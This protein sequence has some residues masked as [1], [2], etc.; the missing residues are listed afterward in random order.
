MARERNLKK[1]IGKR[2]FELFM[3][4]PLKNE[5][6]ILF[7]KHFLDNIPYYEKTDMENLFEDLWI[8]ANKKWN[9]YL[10]PTWYDKK[11]SDIAKGKVNFVGSLS[12]DERKDSDAVNKAP[13]CFIFSSGNTRVLDYEKYI[14]KLRKRFVKE[15]ENPCSRESKEFN[16]KG[17]IFHCLDGGYD[18]R[19]NVYIPVSPGRIP[20]G[21]D[22]GGLSEKDK[23]RVTEEIWTLIKS[24]IKERKAKAKGQRGL[25]AVR[26]S[27]ELGFISLIPDDVFANYLKWYDYHMGGDYQIPK[28]L[29]FRT[30]A[31]REFLEK[32]FRDEPDKLEEGKRKLQER[33]KFIKGLPVKGED[34]VEKGIKLIYQAIHRK[35]YPSKKRQGL[36]NCPQ[37]GENCPKNCLYLETWMKDFNK[38]TTLFKPLHTLSPEVLVKVVHDNIYPKGREQKKLD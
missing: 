2:R 32:K 16:S 11:E 3:R 34:N 20:L 12:P 18:D 24:K 22:I 33:A 8:K 37:H 1:D 6:D 17:W 30:I 25:P 28:G 7:R 27:K 21:I 19:D 29:P 36:F 14:E 10:Y 9:C 31:R 26:D 13:Y 35:L 5:M 15:I 4:D 38:K 23:T